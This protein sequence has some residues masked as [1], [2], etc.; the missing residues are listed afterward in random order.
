MSV[1]L[2]NT[3][4]S[5]FTSSLK[6][7]GSLDVS[8]A[9]SGT[10]PIL[11]RITGSIDLPFYRTDVISNVRLNVSGSNF[12]SSFWFPI[13]SELYLRDFAGNYAIYATVVGTSTGRRVDFQFLNLT[14]GSTVALPTLTISLHARFYSFPWA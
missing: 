12:S 14:A 8:K 3:Q 4:S 2:S 7:E 6:D 9:F 13:T 10:I 11:G 5:S 1:D